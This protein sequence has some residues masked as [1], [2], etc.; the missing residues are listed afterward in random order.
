MKECKKHESAFECVANGCKQA[1]PVCHEHP[2]D[3][4]K[5]KAED[6]PGIETPQVAAA[7]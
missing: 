7:S 4:E 1:P 6:C 5:C 2:Y 3:P